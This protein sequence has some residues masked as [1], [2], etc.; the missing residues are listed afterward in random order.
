MDMKNKDK[1]KDE[2]SAICSSCCNID[3]SLVTIDILRF[4][5][6]LIIVIVNLIFYIQDPHPKCL[7]NIGDIHMDKVFLGIICIAWN[8]LVSIIGVNICSRDF[9]AIVITSCCCCVLLAE[10]IDTILHVLLI[11]AYLHEQNCQRTFYGY[12]I[13]ANIGHYFVYQFFLSAIGAILKQFKK[14]YP[15]MVSSSSAEVNSGT[16]IVPT[17]V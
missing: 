14:L 5:G 11:V 12:I 16:Q 15:S 17:L 1:N 4:I 6:A 9:S 2:D 8:R 13:I 10:L 3:H 7:M